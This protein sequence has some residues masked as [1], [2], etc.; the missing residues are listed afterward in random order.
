MHHLHMNFCR[1]AIKNSSSLYWPCLLAFCLSLE[2][3]RKHNKKS[4]RNNLKGHCKNYFFL[5]SSVRCS[6]VRYTSVYQH[7]FQSQM[8]AEEVARVLSWQPKTVNKYCAKEKKTSQMEM[9]FLCYQF[10]NCQ[11]ETFSTRHCVY[12]LVYAYMCML[13]MFQTLN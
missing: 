1:A 8:D 2:G 9:T 12:L 4:L 7:N 5:R 10:T 13:E 11:P 6:S 3:N